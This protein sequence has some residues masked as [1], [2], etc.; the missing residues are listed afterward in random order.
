MYA[1]AE[2]II[3]TGTPTS[4]YLQNKARLTWRIVPVNMWQ[5]SEGCPWI[6]AEYFSFFPMQI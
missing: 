3:Y 4:R 6:S 2:E 5:N 1:K